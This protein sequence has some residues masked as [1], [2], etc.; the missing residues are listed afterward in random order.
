MRTWLPLL[1]V[2]GCG[3]DDKSTTDSGQD[4]SLPYLTEASDE[5]AP[6]IV[7][8]NVSAAV[9][10]A[11]SEI[12]AIRTSPLMDAYRSAESG[13][14]PS[15]PTWAENDDTAY[16]V[17]TCTSEDGTTFNGIGALVEYDDF[18]N[19]SITYSGSQLYLV[20]SM[21]TPGGNLLEGSGSAVDLAGVGAAGELIQYIYLDGEFSWDGPGSARTWLKTDLSPRLELWATTELEG[22]RTISLSGTLEGADGATAV[23]FHDL[24]VYSGAAVSGDCTPEPSGAVSVLDKDGNWISLEF[25]GSASGEWPPQAAACDGC[26]QGWFQGL[27]VGE[28][29]PDVSGL[30]DWVGPYPWL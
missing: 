19:G 26:A 25:D 29:C 20:G 3:E 27:H 14:G 12:M 17:D 6:E 16:W 22:W 23:V 11:I 28:V 13:A 4:E 2:L 10:S 8:K 18:S 24:Q 1:L 15:C 30:R 7:P 9:E 21:Q 5:G